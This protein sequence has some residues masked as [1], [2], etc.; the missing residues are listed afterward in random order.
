MAT[1]KLAIFDA[2]RCQ[3]NYFILCDKFIFVFGWTIQI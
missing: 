1:K 2:I 3:I